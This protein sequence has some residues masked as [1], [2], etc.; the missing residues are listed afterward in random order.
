MSLLKHLQMED[1]NWNSP[2]MSQIT[3]PII[4]YHLI[5]TSWSY[6]LYRKIQLTLRQ[7]PFN[8]THYLAYF[9]YS[10]RQDSQM[11]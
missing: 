2:Q 3:H 9:V 11:R 5:P 8:V 1:N 6:T 10:P 4:N 7:I